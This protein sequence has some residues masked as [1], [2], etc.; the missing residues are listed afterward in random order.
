MVRDDAW[1]D[2]CVARAN[3]HAMLDQEILIIGIS[4]MATS[5]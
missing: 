4:S 3:K 5:I 1:G 2:H